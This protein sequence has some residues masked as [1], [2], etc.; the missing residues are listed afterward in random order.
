VENGGSFLW[1][2]I[3]V[4]TEETKQNEGEMKMGK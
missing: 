4:V 3:V 1:K 2:D